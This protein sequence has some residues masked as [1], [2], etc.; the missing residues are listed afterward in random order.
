[1]CNTLDVRYNPTYIKTGDTSAFC[2]TKAIG[3]GDY[4]AAIS[5]VVFCSAQEPLI[6]SFGV[7]HVD[8]HA[9]H[10]DYLIT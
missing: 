1:M 10:M 5:Q 2:T 6:F 3:M 7:S 4:I 9:S 8:L